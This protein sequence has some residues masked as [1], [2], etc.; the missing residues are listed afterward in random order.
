MEFSKAEF[1]ER[2]KAE[3]FVA[4]TRA[5]GE[6]DYREFLFVWAFLEDGDASVQVF[7]EGGPGSLGSPE[8]GTYLV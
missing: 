4:L 8:L 7:A 3:L 6:Q 2:A 5:V 1:L